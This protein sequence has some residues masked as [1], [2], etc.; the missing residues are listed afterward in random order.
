MNHNQL[1]FIVIDSN[2]NVFGHY[3]SS[4]ID[5]IDNHNYDRNMFIFTLNN[6]GR[7]GTKKFNSKNGNNAYTRICN[8]NNYYDCGYY[9]NQIDTNRSYINSYIENCFSGIEKRTLTGNYY[10][11]CFTTKRIIVIQMK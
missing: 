8:N 6:N 5:K 2:D 10:P 7:S 1:Y 3:H 9:I 4:I 11:T